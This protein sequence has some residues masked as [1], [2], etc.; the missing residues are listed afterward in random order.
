MKRKPSSFSFC[1]TV[2]VRPSSKYSF[3]SLL[4]WGQ[5][6]REPVVGELRRQSTTLA[7]M[8]KITHKLRFI[9]LLTQSG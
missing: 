1:L 4:Y 8:L 3:P 7:K 9:Y 6:I 5:R 2:W